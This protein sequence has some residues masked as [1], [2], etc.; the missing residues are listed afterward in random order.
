MFNF[1]GRQS[2]YIKND[3]QNDYNDLYIN[4]YKIILIEIFFFSYLLVKVVYI[5]CKGG[6]IRNKKEI[7]FVLI[8]YIKINF[9]IV[10]IT[11]LIQ[12]T[13]KII[14]YYSYLTQS[15]KKI[16]KSFIFFTKKK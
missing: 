11:N 7:I 5:I 4:L 9:L 14:N 10:V 6:I 13:L 15:K 2:S 8:E 16:K 1:Y 3:L 12:L